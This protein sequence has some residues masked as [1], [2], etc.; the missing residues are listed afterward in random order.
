MLPQP[1][2]TG[3]L[4]LRSSPKSLQDIDEMLDLVVRV[5]SLTCC[6]INDW[7][8]LHRR[9]NGQ[10]HSRNRRGLFLCRCVCRHELRRPWLV[11]NVPFLGERCLRVVGTEGDLNWRQQLACRCKETTSTLDSHLS[12][13]CPQALTRDQSLDSDPTV[14][15]SD[16]RVDLA[17]VNCLCC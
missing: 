1:E 10:P 7:G 5:R 17:R 13:S 4:A 15:W 11:A 16:G 8:P 6:R 12:T 9:L 3:P 2:N 14:R